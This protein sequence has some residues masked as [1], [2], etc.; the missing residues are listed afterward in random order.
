MHWDDSN[1]LPPIVQVSS[2]VFP[3]HPTN[4]LIEASLSEPHPS[5]G[6]GEVYV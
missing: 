4:A 3:G 6:C 2:K 5:V 1:D